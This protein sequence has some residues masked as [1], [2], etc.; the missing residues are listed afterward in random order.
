M[1]GAGRAQ[2]DGPFQPVVGGPPTAPTIPAP[3]APVPTGRPTPLLLQGQDYVF[4]APAGCFDFQEQIH[5]LGMVAEEGG[6]PTPCVLVLARS[7]DM[8]MNELSIALAERGIRMARIDADRCLDLALTIYTDTPLLELDRW[9]LRP[10]LV[11]R[12][13]FELSAM[14]VDPRTIAGSYALD[15]WRTVSGWLTERTDWAHVN[16]TRTTGHLNRLTQLSDATAFGLR[17]PRTAV[18]TQPGRSRPGGGACIVK[19]TG[20]HLLEPRPGV[21]H[22]L[23]PRP[24]DT[25]RAGDVPEPAPV[26]VQQ[27]LN[28]DTELRV[29]VVGEQLIGYQVDKFDPAQL[30]VDPDAVTV[31][32]TE[33]PPALADRLLALA[34]HWKLQVAAFDLLVV[35]GDHVF[36]EVNVNCDWRW[37][38]HRAETTEVSDAVHRWV[39]D[40]FGELLGGHQS[41]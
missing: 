8:E 19:T 4:R 40:R 7:A 17:T 37:F 38:E 27:Y 10:L 35:D 9:L 26:I 41:R 34:R 14:P 30:W 16:P 33:V 29:F 1:I 39:A 2:S 18:S 31:R 25:A 32:R 22:G 24:L 5:R 13:H 21:Q 36:L 3:A 12:R 20:R 28:A 23:F 11:W 15:Q 6:D